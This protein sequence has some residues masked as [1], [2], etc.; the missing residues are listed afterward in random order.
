MKKSKTVFGLAAACLCLAGGVSGC[1]KVV[2]WGDVVDF[3]KG[4][5]TENV[6]SWEGISFTYKGSRVSASSTYHL[7]YEFEVT[8]DSKGNLYGYLIMPYTYVSGYEVEA[9]GVSTLTISDIRTI[10]QCIFIEDGVMLNYTEYNSSK[11]QTFYMRDWTYGTYQE[12]LDILSPVITGTVQSM[13]DEDLPSTYTNGLHEAKLWSKK[14]KAEFWEDEYTTTL[15]VE[16]DKNNDLSSLL[17]EREYM[18]DVTD[19]EGEEDEDE[20]EEIEGEVDESGVEYFDIPDEYTISASPISSVYIPTWVKTEDFEWQ[21]RLGYDHWN[22]D[23]FIDE[24]F[25]VNPLAGSN[26]SSIILPL[27]GYETVTVESIAFR[28]IT[29][30]E[31]VYVEG[32]EEE[33]NEKVT[34]GTQNGPFDRAEKIF[35]SEEE[36][37][38]CWH[39]DT[40]GTTPVLW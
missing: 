29:N 13:E 10:S 23:G 7:T 37:A 33:Y 8:T 5:S 9:G 3:I 26:V 18:E 16:K 21:E 11:L 22:P 15:T 28:Y 36:S 30:L 32:S 1:A 24:N 40:D 34:V 14:V 25:G 31:T 2:E 38:G 27:E 19:D 39:Y 4:V 6:S 20:D 12:I 17:W 35:Y